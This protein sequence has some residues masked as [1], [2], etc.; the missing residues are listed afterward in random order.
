MLKWQEDC[1][2]KMRDLS[3]LET[4][5]L[6]KMRNISKEYQPKIDELKKEI[7]KIYVDNGLVEGIKQQ[8]VENGEK[9]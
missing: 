7:Q 4:E 2:Q 5:Y 3:I 8:E 1:A 9:F 6:F